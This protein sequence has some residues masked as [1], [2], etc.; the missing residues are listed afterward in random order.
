VAEEPE[1]PRPP[2]AKSAKPARALSKPA[3]VGASGYPSKRLA[4]CQGDNAVIPQEK[5]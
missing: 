5:L 2:N 1:N 3:A 4:L